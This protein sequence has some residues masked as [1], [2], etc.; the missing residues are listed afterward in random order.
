M[1]LM[2]N[3]PNECADIHVLTT[4][5]EFEAERTDYPQMKVESEN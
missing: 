2:R 5:A 4:T 3:W 1:V